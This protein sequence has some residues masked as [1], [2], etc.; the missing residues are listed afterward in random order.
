MKN[1]KP[2]AINKKLL[3]LL[4]A[5]VIFSCAHHCFAQ[6]DANSFSIS[7]LPAQSG[8]T[9]ATNRFV[10][11]DGK[12]YMWIGSQDGINRY[13][14]KY[15]FH[16]EFSQYY[17]NCKPNIAKYSGARNVKVS[18]VRNNDLAILTISDDGKGYNAGTTKSGNGHYNIG[19]RCNQLQGSCIIKTKPGQGVI[20]ECSLPISIFNN[21][22]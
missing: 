15:F 21:S 4:F 13:N 14:G 17:E 20:I 10:L 11:Q 22:L 19:Q 8:L 7:F 5:A 18:L 2:L 9:Q 1:R 6:V 3:H 12:G 16:F